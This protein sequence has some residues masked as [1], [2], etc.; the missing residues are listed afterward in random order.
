MFSVSSDILF[1][2][3]HSS[4]PVLASV[5]E[6]QSSCCKYC[7]TV[8]SWGGGAASA[9]ST[10][11][12]GSTCLSENANSAHLFWHDG[13]WCCFTALLHFILCFLVKQTLQIEEPC[14]LSTWWIHALSCADTFLSHDVNEFWGFGV[15]RR[16]NFIPIWSHISYSLFVLFFPGDMDSAS[17][18]NKT[19]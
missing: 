9:Y 5:L 17:R 6:C 12:C 2:F 18:A 13:L 4:I 10:L 14:S 7:I 11:C 1:C 16:V 8:W 19:R 3:F 15:K